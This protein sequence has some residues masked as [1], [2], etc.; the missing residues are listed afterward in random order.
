MKI[1][2]DLV[3]IDY[4]RTETVKY[5]V[6]QEVGDQL[7]ALYSKIWCASCYDPLND[8]ENRFALRLLPHIKRLNEIL[9]FKE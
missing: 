2:T 7:N 4:E 9:K 8:E 6:G 3:Y 1:K 5:R